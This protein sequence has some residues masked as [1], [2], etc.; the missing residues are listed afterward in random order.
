MLKPHTPP[1]TRGTV[2][3]SLLR[4]FKP[5]DQPLP[6][7]E[8]TGLPPHAVSSANS[9]VKRALHGE[10]ADRAKRKRKYTTTFTAED[11]AKVGKYAV[12]NGVVIAQKNFKH[13][14]LTESTVRYFKKTHLAEFQYYTCILS[15][16]ISKLITILFTVRNFSTA[17]FS[18]VFGRQNNYLAL[19][20]FLRLW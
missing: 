6:T 5:L 11:R 2:D 9:A 8:Q 18:S 19:Q 7:A 10:D 3:T 4:F 17:I 13:L 14:S 20:L 1:V 12:Q 16:V 15:C